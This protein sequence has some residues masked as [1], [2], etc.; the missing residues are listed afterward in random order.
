MS[1]RLDSHTH[2]LFVASAAD[3]AWYWQ[4]PGSILVQHIATQP[5]CMFADLALVHFHIRWHKGQ[6]AVLIDMLHHK[7]F[8]LPYM[9]MNKCQVS[10]H[11]HLYCA[12][13]L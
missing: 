2:S 6:S 8:V 3:D 1:S 10:K 4:K 5:G 11:V 12:N 7:T 13:D 9:D